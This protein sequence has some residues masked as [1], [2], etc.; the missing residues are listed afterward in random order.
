MRLATVLLAVVLTGCA[1][2]VPSGWER[3][4]YAK[5][6]VDEAL[7]QCHH[8]VQYGSSQVNCMRA[9][10]YAAVYN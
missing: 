4:N 2:L 9:K 10:G 7:A 5:V 3:L 1:S 6:G 8:E